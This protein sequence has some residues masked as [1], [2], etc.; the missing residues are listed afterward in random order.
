MGHGPLCERPGVPT[1]GQSNLAKITPLITAKDSRA[2][3]GHVETW[4]H[5]RCW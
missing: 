3:S 5:V 2:D 1:L 4:Q